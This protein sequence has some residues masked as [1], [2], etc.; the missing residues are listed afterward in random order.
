MMLAR[1]KLPTPVMSLVLSLLALLTL[2]GT[3]AA[4]P[5]DEPQD[6]AAA[7]NDPDRYA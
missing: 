3:G 6:T 1:R 5:F 7:V 2:G 4:A